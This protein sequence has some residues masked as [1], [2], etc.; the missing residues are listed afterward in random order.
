MKNFD[1]SRNDGA[2]LYCFYCGREIPGGL[3]FA[4]FKHAG[5]LVAFCRPGC[6]E[7]FLAVPAGQRSAMSAKEDSPS[8]ASL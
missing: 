3:W 8:L 7:S 4:R 6:V 5:S 2:T 1:A